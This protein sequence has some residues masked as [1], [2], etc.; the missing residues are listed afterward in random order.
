M[1]HQMNKR[2]SAIVLTALLAVTSLLTIVP[3]QVKAADALTVAQ[4]IQAQ[5]GGTITVTGIIVGHASGSQTANFKSPFA[6]DFNVLL[7]DSSSETNTSKLLDVQI[8]SSYRSQFGLQTNPGLVGKTVTVTG[9]AGTYNNFAG[10]KSP[11]AITLGG[12]STTPT[13]NPDPGTTPPNGSGKKVLFDNSH[14]QTAGAAD[15]VIDGGFSDFASALR[16]DGFTVDALERSIPYTFGEQAITYDKLKNYDVF[17]LAEPNVPFKTS[18][19][20][21]MLQYVKAGGSIFFIGDHYN[22]DR[23]KNRWDGSEAMNGYRRGAYNNPALGMSS[24]EANSPAMQNVSSS[25]WLGSNFGIRFRYNAL[26]DVNATDIVAPAQSFG[27]TQGVSSVAM[28]AGST[29]AIIDPNKA[30]GI[31]YI[32]TG[33]SKWGNAVDQG[34]YNGGGRAEGPYAAISKLGSGKAAFIGDS[35]PVED[36]TP[37]YKREE[38]G[39]TKKTYDG[40]KEVDDST[41]LVNTVRWLAQKESYTDFTQVSGLTLDSKTSLLSIENPSTSTEPQKEPWAAPDAGY[42]WYDPK[43]FKFGSYGYVAS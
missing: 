14:A 17:V 21:A 31:V 5:N 23:N 22:A 15:W 24:E 35:S 4:A 3:Q 37:K 34:V 36:A 26:G 6:N 39:Q 20:A 33:V 38:N 43:T 30:K 19:Q 10:V 13:P 41:L 29:L 40:F 16:A 18:E 42:K 9:T 1:K 27:I 28:H 2:L 7:A 25:D 8:T 32:P 11:T 12:D